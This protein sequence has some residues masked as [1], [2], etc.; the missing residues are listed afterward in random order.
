M[1][2]VA[3]IPARGGSKSIPK[4]NIMN[5]CGKPLIAWS[6]EQVLGSALINGIYVSTDDAEIADVS[7][8]YGAEVIKRPTELATDTVGSEQVLVHAVNQIDKSGRQKTDIVVFLQATSPLRESSDIDNALQRF[9][10]EDADSLFSGAVLEDFLIWGQVNGEFSSINY[11]YKNRGLRQNREKQYVENGSI[12][13]FKPEVLRK[14]GNRLGGKI[15]VY[16][17]ELWKTCEIDSYE[18]VEIC[19]YFM[20]SKLLNESQRLLWESLIKATFLER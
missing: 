12:Y 16:E 14:Q 18:D 19:E 20:K 11:D 9:I 7:K 17:M 3:I 2:I 10:D 1:N 5:F 4:K 8:K 6:I 15:I 13:I